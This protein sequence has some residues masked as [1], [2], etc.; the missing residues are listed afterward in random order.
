M[1]K[2]GKNGG[3][4]SVVAEI[5]QG[6]YCNHGRRCKEQATKAMGLCLHG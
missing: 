4:F 2:V 5:R 1:H 6:A 3:A